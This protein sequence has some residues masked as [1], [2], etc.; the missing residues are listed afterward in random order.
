MLRSTRNDG[1]PGNGSLAAVAEPHHGEPPAA[2]GARMRPLVEEL[3]RKVAQLQLAL[4]TR[5]V[6][7]QAKG[8]LVER[9]AV[10]PDEAFTLLRSGARS[11]RI[12][13]H[14]LA[15]RVV[16]SRTTPPELPAPGP[17]VR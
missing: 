6:I 11:N 2:D 15:A 13:I 4:D 9:Y 5:V 16:E 12:R 3:A 1:R 7:E 17:P 14:D 10:S 8:V